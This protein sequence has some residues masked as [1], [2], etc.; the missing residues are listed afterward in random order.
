ML[1]LCD[2]KNCQST[3][4][5]HMQRVK[6]AMKSSHMQSV[7]MSSHMWSVEPA[8][9]Q[10]TYKTF[11]QVSLCD[12]KNCQSTKSV[13]DD[14]NCQ[15]TKPMYDDKNCQSIKCVHMWKPEMPQSSYKK[16]SK[17]A[18]TQ[19]THS[20]RNARKQIGTQPEVI[21]NCQDST[22]RCWY[23]SVSTNVCQ[24]TVMMQSNHIHPVKTEC[25]KKSQVNARLQVQTSK[26]KKDTK[27]QAK[28]N[29]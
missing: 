9:L 22:S 12:D 10:S 5:I 6:S 17:L 25:Q 14:K 16:C 20:L 4:S 8:M 26:C 2:D 23:P 11:N 1:F 15:S 13:F 29:L 24:D 18:V 19:L 28:L 3:K 27:P 21:R 7:T